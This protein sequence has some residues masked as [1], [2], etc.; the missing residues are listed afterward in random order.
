MNR[1]RASRSNC[2]MGGHRLAQ[3]ANDGKKSHG[4]A[5]LNCEALG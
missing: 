1:E 4:T 3:R 5:D 2:F